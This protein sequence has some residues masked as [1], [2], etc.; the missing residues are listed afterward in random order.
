VVGKNVSFLIC[1]VLSV[2][3]PCNHIPWELALTVFA[4]FVDW[5]ITVLV[6]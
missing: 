2:D 5:H 3:K 4:V 6:E 1:E